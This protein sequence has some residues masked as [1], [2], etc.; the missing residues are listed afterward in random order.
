[1]RDQTGV[2]SSV[3]M[4]Y[5]PKARRPQNVETLL[6]HIFQNAA[7]KKMLGEIPALAEKTLHRILRAHN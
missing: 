2:E 7:K 4:T 6:G 5:L 1:M 3:S